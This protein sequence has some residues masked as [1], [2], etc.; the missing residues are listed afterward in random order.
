MSRVRPIIGITADASADK[1]QI[2]RS[3]IEM[4][5]RAGG[6]PIILP[7][8][9]ACAEQYVRICDGIMLTGGNDPITTD[10]R[11][12][13]LPLHPKAN[14]IDPARQEFELAI[15][16]ALERQRDK[17]VL[18][19]CLGM[20]L[21]GLHAGGTIDQ[22]LADSLR[23]ADDHWDKRSHEVSGEIGCAV[24]HS[25]HRQALTNSG[26]MRV[27]AT[28]SDGVIEAIQRDD[29]PFYI[30]VQW[31][32]ERTGDPKLGLGLIRRLVEAAVVG[33]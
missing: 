25:H 24:V 9:P 2:G 30:G 5:E 7:C 31:H 10:P 28:S 8:I 12:G 11:L 33:K 14:P 19:I 20:Q 6:A 22:H 17:P 16:D 18:G 4:V 3:Y 32:P 21:M 29:R 26:T 13:G 27:I 1:F 23:T 15:L